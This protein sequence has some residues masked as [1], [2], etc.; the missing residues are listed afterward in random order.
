MARHTACVSIL[1]TFEAKKHAS[2]PSFFQ[3]FETSMQ[4]EY[5]YQE[6]TSTRGSNPWV[7]VYVILP[8]DTS[9]NT[10]SRRRLIDASLL[11]LKS[12]CVEGIMVDVW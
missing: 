7:H 2:F 8:L 1:N 6:A 11:A 10:V 12:T 5:T 9:N 4:R 3:E